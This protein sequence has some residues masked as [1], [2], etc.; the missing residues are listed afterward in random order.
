MLGRLAR[1]SQTLI[2]S[3]VENEVRKWSEYALT[4]VTMANLLWVP[5]E[6]RRD[7]CRDF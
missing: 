2:P 6:V 4:S 3:S 7:L 5:S 1:A